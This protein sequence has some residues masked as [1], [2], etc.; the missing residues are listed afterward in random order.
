MFLRGEPFFFR[1]KT[2][3][4][5]PGSEPAMVLRYVD[6][7]Q[8]IIHI[9]VDTNCFISVQLDRH[10]WVLWVYKRLVN[11]IGP[12]THT[13]WSNNIY[14]HAHNV[15]NCWVLRFQHNY[16]KHGCSL[17]KPLKILIIG[18]STSS[19]SNPTTRQTTKMSIWFNCLHNFNIL[20]QILQENFY[21]IFQ[22]MIPVVCKE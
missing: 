14:P 22:W 17:C 13:C 21:V 8:S 10:L 9:S 11:P 1:K 4:R 18:E 7:L 16:F 3:I 20:L 12:I 5:S 19:T 2:N 15:L 6:L